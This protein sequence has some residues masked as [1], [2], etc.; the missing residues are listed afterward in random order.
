ML[1][2]AKILT[3]RGLVCIIKTWREL[4]DEQRTVAAVGLVASVAGCCD[5]LCDLV[6][7]GI[8]R[9]DD[10]GISGDGEHGSSSNNNNHNSTIRHLLSSDLILPH[11]LTSAWQSILLTLLAVTHFKSALADAYCDTHRIVMAEY[12]DWP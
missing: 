4:R 11:R 9:D 5:P 2:Q 3:N 10:R 7:A 6:A 1:N 12:R 8:S